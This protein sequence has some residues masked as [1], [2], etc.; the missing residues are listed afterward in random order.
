MAGGVRL[1]SVTV[2]RTD[3]RFRCRAVAC[4]RLIAAVRIR[5]DCRHLL[6]VLTGSVQVSGWLAVA[7]KGFEA[8]LPTLKLTSAPT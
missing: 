5:P 7:Y 6:A 3:F 8:V 4:F 1:Q 2:R